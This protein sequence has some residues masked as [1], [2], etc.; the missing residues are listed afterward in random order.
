MT[1]DTGITFFGSGQEST[2]AGQRRTGDSVFIV[3]TKSA[4]G[5]GLADAVLRR[6]HQHPTN[7]CS[8]YCVGMS[9]TGG[10][11]RFNRFLPAL[12]KLGE[13][14]SRAPA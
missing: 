2:D 12:R 9:L 10:V 3:E 6:Y 5:H 7:A 13:M 14:P 11:Q 8:K 4:H 1:I